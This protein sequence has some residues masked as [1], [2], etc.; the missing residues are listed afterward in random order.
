MTK[1]DS[2]PNFAAYGGDGWSPRSTSHMEEIGNI[3]NTCATCNDD[4][5]DTYY[6]L[7]N[8]YN[9]INGPDCDDTDQ[10]NWISCASCVDGDSDSRYVGCD[11]Y[12]VRSLDCDDSDENNWTASGCANC[13]DGDSD[14]YYANCDRYFNI[15]GPDNCDS[16]TNNWTAY[17]NVLSQ[18]TVTSDVS[19]TLEYGFVAS[20][21]LQSYSSLTLTDLTNDVVLFFAESTPFDEPMGSQD[22]QLFAGTLYEFSS[23]TSSG[24]VSL[25]IIPAPASGAILLGMGGLSGLVGR[26][27]R[28]L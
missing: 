1:S 14:S 18:F 4:D 16:N 2:N 15:S 11:Q 8:R 13:I 7:C 21:F 25:T 20:L 23:N 22:F 3:W 12:V 5:S 6:G 24:Q 28:R 17:A 26:R 19:V 10:D 27:R 9:G